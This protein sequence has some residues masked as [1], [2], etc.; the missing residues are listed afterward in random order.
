VISYAQNAEDVVLARLFDGGSP[1]FYVDLGAGHPIH[2]SV[3]KHFYDRG[4][5]GLNVEPMEQE[6]LLLCSE[7]PRD[8]NVRAAVSDRPGVV[9]LYEAPPENRGASTLDP[10]LA[11]RYQEEGQRF[12][13]VEVPAVTLADLLATNGVE[14]IDFLKVDVEGHE[15]AVLSTVDWATTRPRVLVVEA[16]V[17][18][19]TRP[20]HQPWESLVIGAGYQLALFDGINRFYAQEGDHEAL[21]RLGAPAHFLDGYEPWR[22]LS[23][24]QSARDYIR[25]LE[26]EIGKVASEASRLIRA[27][28]LG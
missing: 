15:A 3:T 21:E 5:H 4:W 23:Q 6:Y 20:A 28:R 13:P 18:N 14:R 7:R 22:W 10:T 16:T 17:P 1:G 2:D 25:S 26:E 9:T 11:E 19:S 12:V 24:L 8:V 27:T